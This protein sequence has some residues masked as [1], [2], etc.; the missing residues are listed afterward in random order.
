MQC[1]RPSRVLL[2]HNCVALGPISSWMLCALDGDRQF[3]LFA[4]IVARTM[5]AL[6]V[7]SSMYQLQRQPVP[8]A[9]CDV[10]P[11]PAYHEALPWTQP[12]ILR[13]DLSLSHCLETSRNTP[14]LRDCTCN[15]FEGGDIDG[16]SDPSFQTLCLYISDILFWWQCPTDFTHIHLLHNLTLPVLKHLSMSICCLTETP[17]TIYFLRLPIRIPPPRI[18]IGRHLVTEQGLLYCLQLSCVV[19]LDSLWAS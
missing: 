7:T 19:D 4:E 18:K 1:W 3:S 6:D 13:A 17:L 15:L 9:R 12:T 10:Q 11:Y 5:L 8:T 14:N 16:A 2:H